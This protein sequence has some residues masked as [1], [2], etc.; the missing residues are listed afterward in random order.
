MA[1]VAP[2]F[3]DFDRIRVFRLITRTS[4]VVSRQVTY[5]LTEDGIEDPDAT[6]IVA[7]ITWSEY[8]QDGGQYPV[9]FEYA[10]KIC[11]GTIHR[12]PKSWYIRQLY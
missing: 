3:M 6:I 12:T 7:D 11:H 1:A 8:Q 10:G 5:D 9:E 4:S 2:T